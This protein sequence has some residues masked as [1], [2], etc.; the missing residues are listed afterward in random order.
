MLRCGCI[1]YLNLVKG[2]DG[3]QCRLKQEIKSHP[4]TRMTSSERKNKVSEAPLVS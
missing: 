3:M 4:I 2:D 1:N